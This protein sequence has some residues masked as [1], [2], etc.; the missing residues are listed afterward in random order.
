V[1]LG[2]EVQALL[3]AAITHRHEHL[4]ST[5]DAPRL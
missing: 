2:Q 4:L 3:Y 1:Q 5:P